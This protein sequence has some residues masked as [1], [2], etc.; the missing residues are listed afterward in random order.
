MTPLNGKQNCWIDTKLL[1]SYWINVTGIGIATLGNFFE[2]DFA[3]V[4]VHHCSDVSHASF[5][6]LASNLFFEIQQNVISVKRE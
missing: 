2:K 3:A 6:Y 4:V 1:L 5:H